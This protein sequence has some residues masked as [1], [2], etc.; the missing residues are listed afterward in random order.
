[1]RAKI[2][3]T[4]SPGQKK[5]SKPVQKLVKAVLRAEGAEGRVSI[6]FVAEAE[7]R[8]LNERFRRQDGPTDVLSFRQADGDLE[9]PDPTDSGPSE[10]GEVIVCPSVVERYAHED[11]GDPETQL[12]WTVMHGV[13]H[14]L[15][16]DH[17]TDGGQMRAREQELLRELDVEI[18]AVAK[19]LE[20]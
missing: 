16:H 7:M 3:I 18:R 13:L 14:L 17:E 11:G 12:G 19:A 1:M 20:R 2:E 9:W 15:G 10:L 4:S 5:S 8:D 6:V